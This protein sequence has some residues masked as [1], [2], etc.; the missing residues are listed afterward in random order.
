MFRRYCGAEQVS[1]D[2]VAFEQ[3]QEIGLLLG[4]HAFGDD[5]QIQGMSQGDDGRNNTEIV[6]LMH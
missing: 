6:R 2:L 3:P 4:L 5:F 1:L